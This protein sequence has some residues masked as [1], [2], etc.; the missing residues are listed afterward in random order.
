MYFV[1]GETD[2]MGKLNEKQKSLKK[3]KKKGC[4]DMVQ[5]SKLVFREEAPLFPVVMNLQY[6]N[7]NLDKHL[8]SK[9]RNFSQ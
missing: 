8:F 1:R 5:I 4:C 2:D 6:D 9:G 7:P 3:K